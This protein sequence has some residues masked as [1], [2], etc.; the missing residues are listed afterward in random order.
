MES[1]TP[2]M[3]TRE[4]FVLLVTG[5]P[6]VGKSETLTRVH[7]NLGAD[8]I[9]SA[10][11]DVDELARSYPATDEDRHLAHLRALAKSFRQAGHELLLVAATAESDDGLR[12]WLEAAGAER[13]RC[14]VHLI[15][16]P[17]TLEERVRRREAAEWFGL[18][19]LLE[20]ARRLAAMRFADTDLELNTGKQ[21]PGEV[22]ASIVTEIRTRLGK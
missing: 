14:V 15:A 17:A 12:A 3:E 10:A 2:A 9:D 18:P 22:A 6:G 1:D 8:G 21:G 13:R 11:I 5:A 20:S 4:P 16:S 19:E 7:D